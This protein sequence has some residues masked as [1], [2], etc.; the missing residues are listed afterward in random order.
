MTF[1]HDTFHHDIN[2]S[3]HDINE[4]HH[5]INESHHDINESRYNMK[6]CHDFMSR[7]KH[8]ILSRYILSQHI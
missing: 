7:Y 8:E 4:S 3:R 6:F 1:F 2:E 5:D